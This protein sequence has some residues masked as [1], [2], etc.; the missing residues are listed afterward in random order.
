MI[1]YGV[2]IGSEE[3]YS[4]YAQVGLTACAAPGAPTAESRDNSSIFPAYNEVLDFFAAD[5][6]LEALVLLHEDVELR[7]RAFETKVRIALCDPSVAVIGAV[8]ARGVTSLAW[9]EGEGRGRCPETR[10]VIDYGPGAYDV[11]AVD[12]LLLI[13]SPWAVRNLRFDATTFRGFHA[14]DVDICFQARAAG[15]RVRTLEVDLFH[16]TKGGVGDA[17]AYF[18]AD[19]GFRSKWAPQLDRAAGSTATGRRDNGPRPWCP[20]DQLVAGAAT[21]TPPSDQG[22]SIR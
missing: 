14:Y 1:A 22:A 17:D 5:E 13:L 12:G 18:R 11:D 8:G 19:R 3:K 6:D 9:W 2:C 10:G 16:H 15:K 20:D 7:D 21:T 4:Q